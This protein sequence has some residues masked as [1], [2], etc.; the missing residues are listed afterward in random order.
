MISKSCEHAI[1]NIY[2]I[3]LLSLEFSL[4]L[5]KQL[6]YSLPLNGKQLAT[7]KKAI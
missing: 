5:K 1:A 4:R 7:Y 3:S 6:L 2:E